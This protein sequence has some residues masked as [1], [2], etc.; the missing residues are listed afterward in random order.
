MPDAIT[1]SQIFN[2][3]SNGVIVTDATGHITHINQQ[4]EAILGFG[5]PARVRR[6]P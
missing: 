4:A 5:R 2:T 6:L 1:Y 3:I